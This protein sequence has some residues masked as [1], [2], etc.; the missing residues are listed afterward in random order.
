MTSLTRASKNF[1]NAILRYCNIKT[2]K[3]PAHLDLADIKIKLGLINTMPKSGSLYLTRS[4]SELLPEISFDYPYIS[5]NQ[6]FPF[7]CIVKDK[8][9][10]L[11]HR[12]KNK[13]HLIQEHLCCSLVNIRLIKTF[14][15]K[16]VLHIRDPR[17]AVLSWSY[18][19]QNN[20][21]N[22]LSKLYNIDVD[23][24]SAY[25][26]SDLEGKI[27]YDCQFLFP[28]YVQWLRSWLD[29]YDSPSRNMPV[30]LTTNAELRDN[31]TELF[32]NIADFLGLGQIN[33]SLLRSPVQN[34]LHYRNG[35]RDEFLDIFPSSVAKNCE[36]LMDDQW[37]ER[38]G[39]T[40]MGS[41]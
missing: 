41:C 18:H 29:Y 35:N 1:S 12:R 2:P 24:S 37:F 19:V 21:H 16:M 10:Q 33:L 39:W 22:K 28:L 4:L 25:A 31:P 17:E 14:M 38:F 30:L 7:D 5:A 8:L 20:L 27:L 36:L 6:G 9:D 23:Y 26:E 40:R 13:Y 32:S 11:N 34:Q 3:K 15:G